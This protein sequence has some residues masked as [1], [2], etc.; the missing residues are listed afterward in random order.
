MAKD[1]EKGSKDEGQAKEV[2][3]TA[4]F[5][6]TAAAPWWVLINP[7]AWI[8]WTLDFL[9]WLI[10]IYLPIKTCIWTWK[11]HG[12]ESVS[13]ESFEADEDEEELEARR[14]YTSLWEDGLLVS[15]SDTDN[16]RVPCT[17]W[18]IWTKSC[19]SYEER[20]VFGTREYLGLHTP[21]GQ[22][23]SLKVFGST[24]WQTYGEADE[25]I[26]NFGA[27]LRALGVQP[28]PRGWD[29]ERRGGPHTI[30]IFEE[31]C[32]CWISA[33][34]GAMSQSIVVATSYATLGIPAVIE[35]INET[36]ATAVVCN[37]KNVATLQAAALPA[38][39]TLIYTG[40][41]GTKEE[42]AGVEAKNKGKPGMLSFDSVLQ[43]GKSNI[44]RFPT[45]PPQANQLAVI[46]YTSGSTGKPKGVMLTHS[47]ISAS[48]AGLKQ[49]LPS[50]KDGE[51][52]VYLA[53]L[54]AAHILELVAEVVMI[55][56]GA[57]MGFACPR[58]I[59]SKG[60]IR[61]LSDGTMNQSPGYPNPPGAIQEFRPTFMAAVPVIWDTLKKGVEEE[62]GKK[63]SIVQF[64]FQVAYSAQ[65]FAV[66]QGR[67][68]PLL[69]F[70]VF[71]S[72][73]NMLGGRLKFTV[74]GG[75]PISAEVQGF[76]RTVFG[77]NL[78]QGYGLTETASAGS[79]QDIADTD[80]NVTGPPLASVEL[81]LRSC[82]GAE[83]P[84]DRKGK[85]YLSTD[86]V[87]LEESCLGRGEI[88]I[89]GPS[90]SVG[91]FKQAEKTK[92]VFTADK[93]FRTGD[94]GIF[95]SKGRV[96]IVDR[97]KNLIKLSG[98]EYIAIESM[99]KEYSSSAFV[100]SVNGGVVCFGDG[101][102]R[103]PGALVQVNLGELKKWARGA[104]VQDS[105]VEALCNH[106]EARKAVLKSLTDCAKDGKLGQNEFIGSL[107]LIS[108]TGPIDKASVSSPWTP[109]NGC[110]TA[111]NKMER[112]NI[113]KVCE[114]LI[115]EIKKECM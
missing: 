85:L 92:E 115:E 15:P 55:S 58:S 95:D 104:K 61:K 65:Y 93:W 96:K 77:M 86:S 6:A 60:A 40:L 26:R 24:S 112:R 102:M 110:R 22:K 41:N 14:R 98:G 12:E 54:P 59:S 105:D 8:L 21:E 11:R 7:F 16:E 94:I 42:I 83:D 5:K 80:D 44:S 68:C 37:W 23:L 89:R 17:V 47:N 101:T 52:E 51:D 100:N 69:N 114:A 33:C 113:A 99:E 34:I 39:I 36:G 38:G 29:L 88:C 19:D 97:L 4:I 107:R 2:K 48:A 90:V 27:G 9:I 1:L 74:S 66:K 109:E 25:V 78:I 43:L 73:S 81:K 106:P 72:L 31:T 103:K 35:A 67:T 3:D 46:M 84:R 20:P 50:H 63:S 111:S 70:L 53:Y 45:T 79:I 18:E 62:L 82:D 28:L 64:L 32:A 71:R 10:S 87:H 108:G 56:W 30:L 49:I 91:Y 57:A 75:G 76:I 13:G